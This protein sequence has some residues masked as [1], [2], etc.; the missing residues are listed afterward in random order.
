[1]ASAYIELTGDREDRRLQSQNQALLH[2][3]GD[4][5]RRVLSRYAAPRVLDVGCGNGDVIAGL[6]ADI[7]DSRVFGIDCVR[8]QVDLAAARH[9]ERSFCLMDLEE[10][11][12]VESLHGWMGSEGVECFDV[13]NCSMALMHLRN[14]T[15]VLRDLRSFLAKDGTLIVREVDDGLQLA[16]P[17][18]D[19]RF[20]RL[21]AIYEGD[22]HMGD[23][24]CGCGKAGYPRRIPWVA[25]DATRQQ[26]PFAKHH[27]VVDEHS[28]YRSGK[29]AGRLD[30]FG[31]GH[32]IMLERGGIVE[33]LRADLVGIPAS[34]HEARSYRVFGLE[35]TRAHSHL[36][37]LRR[38]STP[39]L[40]P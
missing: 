29:R 11:S 28:I 19:G 21:F 1:M 34:K 12:F 20:K 24:H 16:Y 37:G 8:R 33:L 39:A 7:P 38:V 18:P 35:R 17:D 6:T 15:G 26:G 5:Y 3:D 10:D 2:F 4:V 30:P 23:R 32:R 25:K 13:V 22:A 31:I 36:L 14:P 40:I 27:P 9:P